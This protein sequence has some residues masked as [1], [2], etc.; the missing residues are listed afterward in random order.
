MAVAKRQGREKPMI[1]E[2]RKVKG[3]SKECPVL[4]DPCLES[5]AS[6][7][8]CAVCQG[9]CLLCGSPVPHALN[10]CASLLSLEMRCLVSFTKFIIDSNNLWII[11]DLLFSQ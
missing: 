3:R 5:A 6:A 8:A 9:R 1:I 11:L 2:Q 10:H 7:S 4:W